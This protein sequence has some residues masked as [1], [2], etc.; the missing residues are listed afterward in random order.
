MS[1]NENMETFFN[2]AMVLSALVSYYSRKTTNSSLDSF[3]LTLI[4]SEPSKV[5]SYYIL[6]YKP[7]IFLPGS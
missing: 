2:F 7:I 4:L 5:S 6:F 1:T 3:P